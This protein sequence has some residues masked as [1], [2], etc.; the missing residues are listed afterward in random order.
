MPGATLAWHLLDDTDGAQ[1]ELS[2]TPT[3]QPETTR[4]IEVDGETLKV[5]PSLGAGIWY[6]RVRGRQ[7][8]VIGDRTSSTWMM[9]VVAVPREP[10]WG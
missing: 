8:E 2:S 3:F 4:R 5:P 10:V 7:G 1:V 9:D 6:W